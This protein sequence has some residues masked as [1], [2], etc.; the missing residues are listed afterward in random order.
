M[1]F[2][3]YLKFEYLFIRNVNPSFN[4]EFTSISYGV[5]ILLHM[6]L[7]IISIVILI[8][9]VMYYFKK[10]RK[11]TL[12]S[13]IFLILTVIVTFLPPSGASIPIVP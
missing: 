2:E 11:I 1:S 8:P 13:I 7:R 5:D 9:M 4:S 6:S 10:K 3:V 12:I